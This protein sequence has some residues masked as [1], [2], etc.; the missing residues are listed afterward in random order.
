[1]EERSDERREGEPL[2]ESGDAAAPP[3]PP[4]EPQAVA[5]QPVAPPPA[6]EPVVPAAQAAP[7]PAAAATAT[8]TVEPPAPDEAAP[9]GRMR[10]PSLRTMD[11]ETF[12]TYALSAA[13]YLVVAAVFLVP[14]VLDPR[15]IDTFNLVKL[16]TLWF[17]TISALALW[18]IASIGRERLVPRSR[19]AAI[20]AVLIGV[21]TLS[22]L[23]ASSRAV[24]FHG[25]YHR[26]AGLLSLLL[27][28]AMFLLIVSLYRRGREN[29]RE[30][31][32]AVGAA[33]GVVGA[34]VVLQRM[35]VDFIRWL[36]VTGIPPAFP[37]GNL[38]NSSFSGSFLGM[39]LPFLL[40][41]VLS[42]PKRS[43]RIMWIGASA[44]AL[45]GLGFT[46]SRGGILAGGVGLAAFFLFGT[47][48]FG[49]R[50]KTA[51]VA[52][53]L[54]ALILAPVLIG[55]FGPRTGIL[56][57]A[58]ANYR[59]DM[60]TAAVDMAAEDPL[61]GVGPE[62]FYGEYP[63]HRTFD[64]ARTRGL[65]ITDKPHNILL[66]WATTTGVT[67]LLAFLALVGTAVFLVARGGAG[68]LRS[69][70]L[71]ALS[72]GAGL[73]GY[74]AQGMYSVD[75]PPLALIGWISLAGIAALL[76]AAPGDAVDRRQ[77]ER[78]PSRLDGI[79]RAVGRVFGRR[80]EPGA[81]RP[82]VPAVVTIA[83]VAIVLLVVGFM[84]MRAD[85]A[86][87][88]AQRAGTRG[89]SPQAMALYTKALE[90]DPMEAA[91]KGL[92]G[93][94]LE[95]IGT[96]GDPAAPFSAE[97]SLRLAALQYEQAANLQPGNVYFMINAART[98][99]RLGQ[100]FGAKY[101]SSADAWM[102]K[103]ATHDPL[104]PQVHDLYAEVLQAWAQATK[105]AALQQRA[106]TQKNIA[107]RIR[108]G[109]AVR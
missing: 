36:E 22:T 104:D 14:V 52:L 89:W 6:A 67:G 90:L 74:L 30:L 20:A 24:A 66:E 57:G 88:A 78:A 37:I 8:A 39:S 50:R 103:A 71:L 62:G 1:M 82:S 13:R 87:W 42:A 29:L 53:A 58:T 83:A 31:V 85:H 2:G 68:L 28:G 105:D 34:Y 12:R 3:A 72:F 92:T 15:T 43:R 4:S 76:D 32:V 49:A 107:A 27:Y 25:L 73:V 54:V 11:W 44:L 108:A 70:R 18:L 93:A 26:Y 60:W 56:R 33:G 48:R 79:G 100:R 19:T 91:Y 9:G 65:Q 38:G 94:Y 5:Q 51:L 23:L 80:G 64:D 17:C 99:T 45:A 86:A 69:Q 40:T 35:G 77:R 84:P 63:R 75:V 98:Y 109:E 96:R 10:V 81:G 46:Q 41:L 61:L 21:A 106:A 7:E 55:A 16:T 101:F 59:I 97:Q 47:G 95:G 102:G